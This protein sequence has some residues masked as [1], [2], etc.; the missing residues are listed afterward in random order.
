MLSGKGHMGPFCV[1][2][3]YMC[4][5]AKHNNTYIM[6]MDNIY[7]CLHMDWKCA[8]EY[9]EIRDTINPCNTISQ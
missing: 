5:C 4:Y 7:V 2:K 1:V 6:D 3:E 8:Y 9:V